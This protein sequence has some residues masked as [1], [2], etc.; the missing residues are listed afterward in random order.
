MSA[1]QE[2]QKLE[3]VQ[4]ES[5]SFIYRRGS[6]SIISRTIYSGPIFSSLQ[7]SARLLIIGPRDLKVLC[8]LLSYT[9]VLN[10]WLK[11]CTLFLA[12]RKIFF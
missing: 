3:L 8:P 4:T 2:I 12:W 7:W 10:V 1:S 6:I 9:I 11:I 5:W